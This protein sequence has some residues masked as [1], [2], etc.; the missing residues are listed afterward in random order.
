MYL[1][2]LCCLTFGVPGR[3]LYAQRL[4]SSLGSLYAHSNCAES[5]LFSGRASDLLWPSLRAVSV[6]WDYPKTFL[7]KL[8]TVIYVH[9]RVWSAS[10]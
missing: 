2:E 4:R 3:V 8:R 5:S 6:L 1:C 9:V 7:T 10:E